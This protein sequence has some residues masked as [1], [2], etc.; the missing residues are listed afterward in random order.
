MFA[1]I[2]VDI[3]LSTPLRRGVRQ[4]TLGTPFRNAW[5]RRG[6]LEQLIGRG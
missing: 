2:G 1:V 3:C 5:V 6:R 4:N